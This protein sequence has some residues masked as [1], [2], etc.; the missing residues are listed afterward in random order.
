MADD[1]ELLIAG[2]GLNGMLLGVACAGAGLSVAIVDPQNPE[3]M[4]DRGFDGRT[5][6]IAFGSR[7]VLAARGLCPD[8]APAAEPIREIR[9]ADDDSPL[10][11]HY[12]CRELIPRHGPEHQGAMPLGYI[13]ENRV[14]RRVLFDRAR[15]LPSLTLLGGSRVAAMH[16]TETGAEIALD[17]GTNLRARLVAAADGKDSPLRHTAGIRAI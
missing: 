3:A 1:S 11:L 17:V 2:A 14:L 8:I 4:L 13:V 5:S 6:A 10:F 12:D 15:A 7:L 16:A 9:I